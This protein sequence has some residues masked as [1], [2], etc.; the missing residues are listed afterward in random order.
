M[1]F[2]TGFGISVYKVKSIILNEKTN[3]YSMTFD[4][5]YPED[6][7]ISPSAVDY[8]D[9]LILNTYVIK[10]KKENGNNILLSMEEK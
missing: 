10:Y 2:P 1:Y 7:M 6:S 4:S 3:E 9:N 8:E 5:I